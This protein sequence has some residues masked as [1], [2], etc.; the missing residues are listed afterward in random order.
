MKV[1][2]DRDLCELHG[3]CVFAAPEVFRFDDDGELQYL[4]EVD[5]VLAAAAEAGAAVCPVAA[6]E[7]E[8]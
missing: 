1:N 8:Q 4:E 6:I 7:L 5:D 3:Q 2:V